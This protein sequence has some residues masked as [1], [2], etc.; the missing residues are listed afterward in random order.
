MW[1]I[2]SL[3]WI[4]NKDATYLWVLLKRITLR[5][6]RIQRGTISGDYCAYRWMR[7]QDILVYASHSS[8]LVRGLI[9]ASKAAKFLLM[10]RASSMVRGS[11]YSWFRQDHWFKLREWRLKRR[12][13]L[14]IFDITSWSKILILLLS[15]SFLRHGWARCLQPICRILMLENL[16][17]LLL[18]AL[19]AISL[20]ISQ[21]KVLLQL[22]N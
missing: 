5:S 2:D 17:L 15:Q 10:S 19:Q 1:F 13:L 4:R 14:Q 6:L 21:R 3:K 11:E 7:L 16:L 18:L 22:S 8:S 20:L 9:H 12:M